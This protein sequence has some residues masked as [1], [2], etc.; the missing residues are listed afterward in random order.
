MR[1]WDNTQVKLKSN[2]N[3]KFYCYSSNHES[4][5]M[6]RFA[7]FAKRHMNLVFWKDFAK[8]QTRT[9]AILLIYQNSFLRVSN[10]KANWPQQN[11]L[12]KI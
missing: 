11:V 4:Y 1:Q 10:Q 7:S 6:D 2:Q 5:Q 3:S 12:R 8:S 9:T